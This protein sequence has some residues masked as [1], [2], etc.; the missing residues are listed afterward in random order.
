MPGDERRTADRTYVRWRDGVE[1]AG[2]RRARQQADDGL[3]G[4]RKVIDEACDVV[5]QERFLAGIEDRDAIGR[6]DAVG[7]GE[8]EINRIAARP[9]VG[10]LQT[11]L[12]GSGRVLI[13]PSGTE[14]VLRVMV[15]AADE[16]VARQG[17][18]R[19]VEA[20]RAG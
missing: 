20:V 12:N 15:E 11:E 1:A 3:V 4:V 14:P 6:A 13:R 19:L 8:A 2:D 5:L 16:T 18:E 9:D 7:A 10:R 17:A